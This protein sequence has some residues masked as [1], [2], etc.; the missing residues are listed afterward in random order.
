VE[1]AK[2]SPQRYGIIPKIKENKLIF[3]IEESKKLVL[4][5]N[6]F[7]RLFI[8]ADSLETNIPKIDNYDVISIDKYSIDNSGKTIETLKLQKA[9]DESASQGKTLYFPAGLYLTGTLNLKSNSSLYLSPGAMILGS[10]D[11]KD[12][13]QDEGFQEA[14]QVNDPDNYTN[15]GWKMTY[16]RLILIGEAENVKLWGR[17]MIDGQ[18]AVVRPQG[19]PA[20]LI[21]VRN[22]KNVL[23]EGIMLRDPAAW[24][25]HILASDRVIFRD[26][27]MINDRDV[28]N[29]DGIDP[30]GATNVT[31]DNCFM[32]C[33]DDNIAIKTSG[34]S[35][36][37]R[38]SKNIIV[39]NCVFLSKKSAMKLGTETRM[40]ISNVTFENNEI[41][42]SDRGMSLYSRDGATFERIYFIN[43]HFERMFADNRQ[44][45]LDF[46]V[47]DRTINDAPGYEKKA[48]QIKNVVI[49]NCTVQNFRPNEST[50]SGLNDDHQISGVH[51]IN[52][53]IDG[54]V[55]TSL[56]DARIQINNFVK[57]VTF[58]K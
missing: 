27:K 29:T 31:I 5:I 13:P 24:N 38:D 46:D 53:V 43:N 40:N 34:N 10:S 39:K 52:F 21:R 58:L 25:T 19:K 28:Y 33:S 23:V 55:R 41:V 37:L 18:G 35:N 22:S 2:I 57:D 14:D 4:Y 48:G 11:R 36:L 47:K 1:N 45:I 15:K 20:N 30:D 8:F 17:G 3:D 42:E 54:K 56:K 7:E 12:Y 32:Y 9:I 50:I 49:K 44:R 16:S 26:I 51:F 6:N